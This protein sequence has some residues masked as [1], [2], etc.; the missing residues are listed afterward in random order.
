MLPHSWIEPQVMWKVQFLGFFL[1]KTPL[2]AQK[3]HFLRYFLNWPPPKNPYWKI[4][5]RGSIRA[6][7]VYLW[8]GSLAGGMENLAYINHLVLWKL[9]FF[10]CLQWPL[11]NIVNFSSFDKHCGK[12]Y[13]FPKFALLWSPHAVSLVVVCMPPSINLW[14]LIMLASKD[15]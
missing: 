2:F 3:D 9:L 8:K 12:L 14:I 13:F 11:S 4:E 10:Y 6:D 1:N 7:M 15:L 5:P